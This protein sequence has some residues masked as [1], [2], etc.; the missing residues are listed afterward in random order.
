[1]RI[2]EGSIVHIL[3]FRLKISQLIWSNAQ[4]TYGQVAVF[5][6]ISQSMCTYIADIVKTCI[7]KTMSTNLPSDPISQ[8]Q[9]ELAVVTHKR[10]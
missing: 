7:N 10:T 3:K 1:M 2:V 4:N 6:P 5:L 8:L 9:D